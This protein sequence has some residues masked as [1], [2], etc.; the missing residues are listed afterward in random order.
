[1]H[2]TLPP[3]N[4]DVPLQTAHEEKA[5]QTETAPSKMVAA[6]VMVEDVRRWRCS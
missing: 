3:A 4:E 5:F 2:A 1:M 6:A